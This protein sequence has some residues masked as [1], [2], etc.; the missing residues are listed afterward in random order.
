DDSTGP[1]EADGPDTISV[2]MSGDVLLHNGTWASAAADAAAAGRSGYDFAPMFESMRPFIAQADLAIC[3][4]ETPLAPPEGPFENYPVFSA[5]PQV[6][7]GLQETGYDLCTTASNHSVDKG[8]EGVARTI[9][10]FD[11]NDLPFSGTAST[12]RQSRRTPF[13]DAAGAKVAVL[14][15]TYGTNGLPVEEPW[16]VNLIDPA[17]IKRDAAKATRRGADVVIVALHDGAEYVEEPTAH[18]R[19]IVDRITRSDDI[20]LVYGHHAHTSQPF[21]V[22]NGTWVAYGLGNFIA[23]QETVLPETYR[24]TTAEFTLARDGDEWSVESA[25]FVPTLIT[26]QGEYV[27]SMRVLDARA[28]LADPDTPAALL[29]KLRET[30]DAVREASFGLGARQH[31]LRMARYREP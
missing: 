7:R 30:I 4:L 18:Q 16:S 13:V 6:L 15:Y 25:S 2:A 5:P 27:D 11:R 3:H 21:D 1:A 19:Q 23:Q 9:G 31:G 10:A 17:V 26:R 14:S 12:R 24:G 29:A 22:V 20:D 8:F 28:A